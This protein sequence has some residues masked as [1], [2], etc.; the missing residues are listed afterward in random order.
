MTQLRIF[1]LVV[2]IALA[3]SAA[4]TIASDAAS[5]NKA[6]DGEAQLQGGDAD[7]ALTELAQRFKDNP[8]VKAH[9]VT[10]AEDLML[11]TRKDEGEF[12]LDRA[13][14]VLQKYTKPKM[15]LRLLEGAQFHEYAASRKLDLVKD[16]SKAPKALKLLQAAVTVDVK[17]LG[18]L[19]DISVYSKGPGMRLVLLPKVGAKNPLAYQYIQARVGEKDLF[20]SEIEY[21]PDSGKIVEHYS[22]ITAVAK[23]N[24]D[25]FNLHLPDGVVPKVEMISSDD[26]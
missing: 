25:D 1:S 14:R 19:F 21:M 3:L 11:G 9:V 20:F 13:G 6:L 4:R 23:F 12:L 8:N 24:D 7:K 5:V 22:E 2:S 18:Q 17:E 10:E 26:K 16:F 15:K